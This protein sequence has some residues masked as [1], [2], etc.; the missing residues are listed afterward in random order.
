MVVQYWPNA[1]DQPSER[2]SIICFG[3]VMYWQSRFI[4]LFAANVRRL[5]KRRTKGF[6]QRKW[7]FDEVYIKI[8]CKMHHL[9]RAV[10]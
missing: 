5:R 7:R 10:G 4:A 2:V 9:R 3:M 8:D 1:K 6:R